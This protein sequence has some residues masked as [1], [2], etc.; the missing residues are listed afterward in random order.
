VTRFIAVGVATRA[1]TGESTGWT[2]E[3]PANGG[4]TIRSAEALVVATEFVDLS[5]VST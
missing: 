1:V 5:M 2:A 3:V 4:A